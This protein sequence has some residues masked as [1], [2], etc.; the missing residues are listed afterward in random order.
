MKRLLTTDDLVETYAK[1]KQRG[2]QF[3][4]SKFNFNGIE[5]TKSAF[6]EV[7]IQSSNWWIIPKVQQR[8]NHMITGDLH[9]EYEDFTVNHFLKDCKSLRMLSLGSGQCTH[10]L[11]FAAYEEHFEEIVCIDISETL[12]KDAQNVASEQQ[13]DNIR[14]LAKSIYDYD[15]PEAS[16]DI[17]FFHASLH[18]FKDLD[19]LLGNKVMKTLKPSGKLIINEYVGANRMQYPKHQI[20]AINAAIQLIPN[21][22]RQRFKINLYKNQASGPGILR[23]IVADPSECVESEEILPTIHKHFTTICEKPFGG[24]ILMTCLK[25]L[26]H[27]FV[28]LTPEKERV[29]E[30]LFEFEDDYLKRYPSDFVFGIYQMKS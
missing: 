27:H 22:Y 9:L 3:I 24:N 21:D 4:S 13:L 17:V 6:N 15:F 12:L 18:H 23:M 10:E 20:K 30:T 29:L 5:R 28:T 19:D 26:A 1:I 11:R 25:D 14:F 8:W 7:D 16:F 2:F